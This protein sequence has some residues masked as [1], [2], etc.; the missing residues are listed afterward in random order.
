MRRKERL[1]A[2]PGQALPPPCPRSQASDGRH[3]SH[4]AVSQACSKCFAYVTSADPPSG[5]VSMGGVLPCFADENSG[6]RR[7]QSTSSWHTG[8]TRAGIRLRPALHARQLGT[9]FVS[10]L[11]GWPLD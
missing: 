10:V 3:A 4:S 6:V 8:S 1:V 2:A 11:K 9:G 7:G 5:P